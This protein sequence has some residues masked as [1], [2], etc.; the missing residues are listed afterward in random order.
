[1]TS[2]WRFIHNLETLKQMWSERQLPGNLLDVLPFNVNK[3][4]GT[5][6]SEWLQ[7][8]Y[9]LYVIIDDV[10]DFLPSQ[11]NNVI[12]INP[13]RGLSKKDEDK[14]ISILNEI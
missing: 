5:E 6:I 13:I 3:S 11:Q 12:E 1:M 4:R 9:C 2:T 14:V 7:D 8:K 10:Y